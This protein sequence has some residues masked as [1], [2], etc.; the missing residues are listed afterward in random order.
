MRSINALPGGGRPPFGVLLCPRGRA[1][2]LPVLRFDGCEMA[3]VLLLSPAM[4][5]IHPAV[6]IGLLGREVRGWRLPEPRRFG[7]LNK[8]QTPARRAC[9]AS[10]KDDRGGADHVPPQLARSQTACFSISCASTRIR[11]PMPR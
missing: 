10:R 9:A 6:K 1:Y 4:C 2:T 3:A 11:A 8:M 7:L 5:G